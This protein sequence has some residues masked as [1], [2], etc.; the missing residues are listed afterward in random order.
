MHLLYAIH[1]IMTRQTSASWPDKL[2]S[3]AA[4]AMPGVIVEKR[5]YTA[6]PLPAVNTWL[7]NHIWARECV[8]EIQNFIRENP[9]AKVSFVAHSNGT[10][11]ALKAIKSLAAS[12][13]PTHGFVAIGSVLDEDVGR[14][15]IG[16]LLADGFLG[17]VVSY[18]SD[19]DCAIKFGRFTTYGGLGRFGFTNLACLPY[20]CYTSIFTRQFNRFGH[21]DYFTDANREKTFALIKEDLCL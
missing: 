21:G 3:W 4:H 1:G 11:V 14:S 8:V 15:G 7:L 20:Q 9:G 6:F 13:I 19:C 2:V 18:S 17:R 10:D 16:K 5:E 12:G